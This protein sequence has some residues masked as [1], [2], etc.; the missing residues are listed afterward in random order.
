MREEI[1]DFLRKVDYEGV[2]YA[3]MDGYLEYPPEWRDEDPD[4]FE[5]I[6]AV[7]DV[8]PAIEYIEK[9]IVEYGEGGIE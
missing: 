6:D 9:R 3:A 1:R 8:V 2:S 5:A 4:L 7:L